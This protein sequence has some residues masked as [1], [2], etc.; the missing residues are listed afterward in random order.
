M[1]LAT[2]LEITEL[3]LSS[4][5]RYALPRPNTDAGVTFGSMPHHLYTMKVRRNVIGHR[6]VR[7]VRGF[8][9]GLALRCQVD[10]P[11]P[12]IVQATVANYDLD[13]IRMDELAAS[14]RSVHVEYTLK[15]V[16]VAGQCEEENNPKPPNGLQLILRQ[17][18]GVGDGTLP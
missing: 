14:G 9:P 4:F 5:Y 16:L 7:R 2:E 13:N 8:D 11:E 12:W 10:V 6:H 17:A 1:L 3:P 15:R 18:A